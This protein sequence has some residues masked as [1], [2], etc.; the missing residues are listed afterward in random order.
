M[1]RSTATTESGG[2]RHDVRPPPSHFATAVQPCQNVAP[3]SP[4]ALAPRRRSCVAADAMA[5][6]G[7]ALDSRSRAACYDARQRRHR[8]APAGGRPCAHDSP[9]VSTGISPCCG[10]ALILLRDRVPSGG[11]GGVAGAVSMARTSCGSCWEPDPAIHVLSYSGA[12]RWTA[13]GQDTANLSA[14]IVTTTSWIPSSAGDGVPVIISTKLWKSCPK[15][16][17]T[18]QSMCSMTDRVPSSVIRRT[19]PPWS[20]VGRS[21][22]AALSSSSRERASTIVEDG[23]NRGRCRRRAGSCAFAV[24]V[25]RA[26][27]ARRSGQAIPSPFAL[28]PDRSPPSHDATRSSRRPG[29]GPSAGIW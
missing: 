7:M 18:R 27:A 20:A 10:G 21:K 26:T 6:T 15:D 1:E 5:A 4:L 12:R 24:Y 14:A 16:R 22:P 8:A 2:S 23:R 11:G 19:A 3:G 29:A 25:A 28:S 13:A 17:L 9:A